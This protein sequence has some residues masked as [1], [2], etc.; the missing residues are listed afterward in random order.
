MIGGRRE[1]RVFRRS[2][3]W[4]A[5]VFFLSS[6][7]FFFFFFPLFFSPKG[8]WR[9][10]ACSY[11]PVDSRNILARLRKALSRRLL[12]SP[13]KDRHFSP[14]YF[15]RSPSP[16]SVPTFFRVS[17]PLD[18]DFSKSVPDRPMEKFDRRSSTSYSFFFFLFFF[19][20]DFSQT[21]NW[22]SF[23]FNETVKKF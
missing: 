18:P 7:F 22:K 15:P 1:T 16:S 4:K 23:D 6:F 5:S 9:E 10:E 14:T 21:K 11:A 20:R 13:T 19:I 8:K 2:C 3:G 17:L 12:V